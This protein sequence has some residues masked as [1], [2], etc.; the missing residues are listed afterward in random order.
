M[1]SVADEP[2]DSRDWLIASNKYAIARALDP[3]RPAMINL[4]RNLPDYGSDVL[5]LD[6]YPVAINW[7]SPDP[8]SAKMA[9]Y[10]DALAALH[11]PAAAAHKPVWCWAQSIGY[12]YFAFREPT[13]AEAEG[14]AYMAFVNGTRG[15]HYFL[16]KPRLSEQWTEL[17]ALNNEVRQ[18]TPVL[19]STN[20]LPAVFAVPDP[21]QLVG[22]VYAGREFILAVN[23][24]PAPTTATLNAGGSRATRAS[25]LFEDRTVRVIDGRIVDSFAGYQR[26]VYSMPDSRRAQGRN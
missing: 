25:V 23:T 1:W 13:G 21:I 2:Q 20:T 9:Y 3:G 6:N 24:L 17:C 5:S 19:Y 7:N 16:G 22:K 8:L 4:D 15:I 14:M 26:H 10:R 12:A 11:Q 18:L